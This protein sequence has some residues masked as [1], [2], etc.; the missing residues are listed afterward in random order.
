MSEMMEYYLPSRCWSG[1]LYYASWLLSHLS[2]TTARSYF[3]FGAIGAVAAH[4]LGHALDSERKLSIIL[5]LQL[6]TG[7]KT[8]LLN[9]P[10]IV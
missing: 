9:V 5:I 3:K 1:L 6:T 7:V 2:Y 4:E 10:F 8:G